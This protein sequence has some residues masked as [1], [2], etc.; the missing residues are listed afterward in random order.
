VA[1]RG[2]SPEIIARLN[3]AVN[4]VLSE[5][6]LLARFAEL[7]GTPMPMRPEEFG[8]LLSAEVVKWA[9]VVKFAGIKPE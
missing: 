4:T 5:P 6:R 3:R 8:A 9:K 7:G 1:P 2:T